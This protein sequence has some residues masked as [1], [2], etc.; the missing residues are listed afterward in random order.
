MESFP[1]WVKPDF[2][3]TFSYVLL[4][5]F[6]LNQNAYGCSNEIQLKHYKRPILGVCF[7]II[8]VHILI[9][10][11]ICLIAI[12]R[13]E[14]MK[15]PAYKTMMFLG[16]CDIFSSFIHSIATGL[17]GYHGI[18]FC[19]FPRLIYTLGSIGMGS[20]MGCCIS[21]LVSA[22]IRICDLKSQ[23]KLKKFF[24]GW[25]I[26][27][28]L[29]IFLLYN[30]YAMFLSKPL[31]FNPIYMSWFFDPGIGKDILLQTFFFCIFHA[32]SSGV[33]VYMQFFDSSEIVV[34]IGHIAWQASSGSVC[35]V[36]LTLNKTIRKSVMKMICKRKL[37]NQIAVVVEEN[38]EKNWKIAMF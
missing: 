37:T 20:W 17:L 27:V 29:L 15:T 28:I 6:Q 32:I 34:L 33:Y 22:F 1:S 9:L 8:G 18:S 11:S 23:L 13:S 35:I 24:N 2:N 16:I 19:D 14:Q 21:S 30:L 36:Y 26:Y 3:M 38:I 12:G 10:Y 31:I 25:K 4:N 7:L 5:G